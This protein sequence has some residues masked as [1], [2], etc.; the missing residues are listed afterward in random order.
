MSQKLRKRPNKKENLK[1]ENVK[2]RKGK[3]NDGLELTA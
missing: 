1:F 2:G 3:L